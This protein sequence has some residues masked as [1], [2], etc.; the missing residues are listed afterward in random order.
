MAILAMFLRGTGILPV[1]PRCMCFQRMQKFI[2][3]AQNERGTRKHAQ[4]AHATLGC[5]CYI[6]VRMQ[7]QA[8]NCFQI[9]Q[10][11]WSGNPTTLK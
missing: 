2:K 11:A 9:S 6:R 10:K 7:Y 8:V 1:F 3:H 5:A 4:N